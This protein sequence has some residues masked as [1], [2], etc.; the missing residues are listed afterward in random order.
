MRASNRNN[1]RLLVAVIRASGAV[2]I[3]ARSVAIVQQQAGHAVVVSSGN[4]SAA[5]PTSTTT[6]TPLM[7]V[8][9]LKG[10]APLPTEEQSPSAP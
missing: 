4:S 5:G 9:L 6:T 2:A 1:A 7:A 10:P 8:P 3:G